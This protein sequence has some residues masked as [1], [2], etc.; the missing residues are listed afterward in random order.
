MIFGLGT[1]WSAKGKNCFV[2][3]GSQGL[4]LSLAILL[5][6]KGANVT[7]VARNVENLKKAIAELE[8]HRQ[9]SEQTFRYHSY[10]LSTSADSHAALDAECRALVQQSDGAV[11]TPDAFFLCA[12]SSRPSFF[13]ENTEEHLIQGMEQAYWVQAWSAHAAVKKLVQEQRPGK[14]AFVGSIVS[15][16]SFIGYAPYAPGKHALK[17]LAESLRSECILYNI[18]VQIFFAPTMDSPGLAE[19]LKTK[20]QLTKKFEDSDVTLSCDNAAAV[21]LKGVERGDHH[22]TATFNTQI[23]ANSNRGATPIINPFIGPILDCIAWIAVPFW[24]R[25]CDSEIRKNREEHCN[26][27]KTVGFLPD[28]RKVD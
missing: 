7:I 28:S 15:I 24:R 18:D 26:Y 14:I 13:V 25:G 11:S 6:K 4:G 1:R 20:P 21:L 3:G 10:S 22:I 17:G 12:G 27:L 2:T 16:M 8:R 23:F 19:E 5:V 9:S